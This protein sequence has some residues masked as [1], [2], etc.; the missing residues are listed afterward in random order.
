MRALGCDAKLVVQDIFWLW[1]RGAD[2]ALSLARAEKRRKH[3]ACEHCAAAALQPPSVHCVRRTLS[4]TPGSASLCFVALGLFPIVNGGGLC[5]GASRRSFAER[6]SFL[7][8]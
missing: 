7:D 6:T 4:R 2:R 3:D 1:L 8:L 5:L